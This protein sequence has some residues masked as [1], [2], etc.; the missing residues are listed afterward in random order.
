MKLKLENLD[1]AGVW[2]FPKVLVCLDCRVARFAAPDA[3]LAQLAEAT[4]QN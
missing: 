4:A 1:R 2:I 3:A